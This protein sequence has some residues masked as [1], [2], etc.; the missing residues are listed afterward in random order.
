MDGTPS[1]YSGTDLMSKLM[2]ITQKKASM[3]AISLLGMKHAHVLHKHV[4]RLVAIGDAGSAL[5]LYWSRR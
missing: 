4:F 1:G 3:K 2:L 5:R